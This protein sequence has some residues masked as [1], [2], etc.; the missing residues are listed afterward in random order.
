MRISQ[1]FEKRSERAPDTLTISYSTRVSGIIVLLK[2]PKKLENLSS[3]A[4]LADA[5]TYC[6][7]WSIVYE[8]IYR[9]L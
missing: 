1:I 9:G 5:C 6:I 2:T 7:L 8:L 3:P 4:V